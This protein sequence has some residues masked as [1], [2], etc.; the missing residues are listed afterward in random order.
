MRYAALNMDFDF[1]AEWDGFVP[2]IASIE[3]L[4]AEMLPPEAPPK[5]AMLAEVR[6]PAS[7]FRYSDEQLYALAM[8]VYSLR[9]PTNP[10]P[11]DEL[12]RRGQQVFD[13]QECK[14]CHP[15]PLYTSNQLTPVDGFVVPESLRASDDI[16]SRGVGTDP[17]L[18]LTTRRGT[19]FYKVP[20]LQGVWYRGPFSHDGSVATLEDWFDARRLDDGYVPTGWNPGGKPRAVPG[21]GFG[22]DL[23]DGDKQALIAFL[24]TL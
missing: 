23:S 24:K 22:L 10:H 13:Q 7:H 3:A 9:P 1:L 21:H 6:S 8:F 5:E 2:L 16:R 20:S 17:M 18:A 4:P 15:A 14:K 19:G 11:R 12:A